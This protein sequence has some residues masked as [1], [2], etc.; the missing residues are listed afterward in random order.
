MSCRILSSFFN[1]IDVLDNF[2]GKVHIHDN[3]F[4]Y[5]TLVIP[6]NSSKCFIVEGVRLEK[7]SDLVL[8]YRSVDPLSI[9]EWV[10]LC[11]YEGD[12]LKHDDYP[13][14]L[15]EPK[16][17]NG[18]WKPIL[19]YGSNGTPELSGFPKY[20]GEYKTAGWKFDYD[21]YRES[22]FIPKLRKISDSFTYLGSIDKYDNT[23]LVNEELKETNRHI[24]SFY[25]DSE[26]GDWGGIYIVESYVGNIIAEEDPYSLKDI[27]KNF[28]I[29][30]KLL[31][32][33]KLI[34]F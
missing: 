30:I 19:I 5:G 8:S 17:T 25:F 21:W 4:I 27:M 13:G 6:S 12:I 11:I 26:M 9:G 29:V 33:R 18:E 1:E 22:I 23:L 2:R 14:Y 28:P 32:K 7:Q 3:Y 24:L 34:S 31:R 15:F 20:L 10:D 16:F